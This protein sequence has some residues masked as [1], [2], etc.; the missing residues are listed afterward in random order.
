MVT[1]PMHWLNVIHCY[2]APDPPSPPPPPPDAPVV[3]DS[4][5]ECMPGTTC[6]CM[7]ELSGMCLDWACCP[8]PKAT[9]CKDRRHCCP[10]TLPVCDMAHSR[11]LPKG[12]DYT[13]YRA[14]PMQV[15][16]APLKRTFGRA[17]DIIS[18]H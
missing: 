11:C 12:A 15:K 18:S 7:Q 5:N 6:C 8:L 4:V 17:N 16:V 3:C 13:D 14:E 9:C 2:A 1:G 10:H